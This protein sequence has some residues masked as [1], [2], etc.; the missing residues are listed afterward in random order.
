MV[1]YLEHRSLPRRLAD[2]HNIT[3]MGFDEKHV[4]EEEVCAWEVCLDDV[5]VRL[6]PKIDAPIL[7]T[8]SLYSIVSGRRVYVA[9]MG[10]YKPVLVDSWVHLVGE[11]GYIR[12]T[13]AHT[14]VTVLKRIGP[15]VRV[16]VRTLAGETLV[17]TR[18]HECPVHVRD[19][20]THIHENLPKTTADLVPRRD[21][22][23]DLRKKK[24]ELSPQPPKIKLF[25]VKGQADGH[26]CQVTEIF[27]N[28]HL[29]CFPG[30]TLIIQC[31]QS[32][33]VEEDWAKVADGTDWLGLHELGS[34]TL[35]AANTFDGSCEKE[36]AAKKKRRRQE[37]SW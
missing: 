27:R 37:G 12:V 14:G 32:Y 11:D 5:N 20:F 28:Q 16:E 18:N 35:L 13:G 1:S 31:V 15:H 17:R 26:A 4:L 10:R 8:K 7:G 22:Y 36:P 34:T 21:R 2:L 25:M 6:S 9:F 30:Q 3:A 33:L 29:E 23:G 24:K 19:I